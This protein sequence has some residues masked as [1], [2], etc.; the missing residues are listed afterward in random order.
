M[1]A[2]SCA[3]FPR[4]TVQ[5]G[6]M[7][8]LLLGLEVPV[9]VLVAEAPGQSFELDGRDQTLKHTQAGNFLRFDYE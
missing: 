3:N 1:S 8:S 6:I 7:P 9:A 4:Q 5:H 2:H